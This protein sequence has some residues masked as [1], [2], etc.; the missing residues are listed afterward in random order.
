M[1]I[2]ARNRLNIFL[3][4][5]NSSILLFLVYWI[6]R[7][8]ELSI[9][10]NAVLS[11]LGSVVIALF[12]LFTIIILFKKTNAP[13]LVLLLVY[14]VGLSLQPLRFFLVY[15]YALNTQT[16]QVFST[17]MAVFGYFLSLSTLLFI[18][19]YEINAIL[20]RVKE[21]LI[22]FAILLYIFIASQPLNVIDMES[23][24]LFQFTDAMTISLLYFIL[25]VLTILVSMILLFIKEE[26]HKPYF[27]IA[28]LTLYIAMTL[29]WEAR[30]FFLTALG[31]FLQ[32]GG[33][34]ML[35]MLIRRRYLW[36]RWS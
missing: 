14:S 8:N 30:N 36:F 20:L 13:E 17:Y 21:I 5:L 31:F 10:N 1:T 34:V 12:I 32:V 4:T 27:A 7:S 26:N 19:L 23:G 35:F 24:Y 29:L 16:I 25:Y 2:N 28:I 15:P 18:G 11:I 3:L 9:K 33:F 6:W 22:Y